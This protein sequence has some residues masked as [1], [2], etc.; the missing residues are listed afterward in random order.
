MTKP[1]LRIA[2]LLMGSALTALLFTLNGVQ[3]AAPSQENNP[4]PEPV[5]ITSDT[6]CLD[7][8]TAKDQVMDL[9]SGETLYLTI[10]SKAFTAS[11]HGQEEVACMECHTDITA[12]PHPAFEAQ[13]LREVAIDFSENCQ[14]CHEEQAADHMDG[15]H[16]QKLAE[17]NENA[18]TCSDCHNP[19]YTKHPSEPRADIVTT[20]ARCHSGIAQE[21]RES[22]HGQAL[23]TD[24]NPDVPSC[25]DCH[26]VHN[27]TDPT[28]AQFLLNSPKL[29]ADC[30]ADPVKMEPYHLNTNVLSSYVADFHG[31]TTTLFE[32][33]SPDQL[34][35]TPLCIDCHGI[36]N[37]KSVTSTES[38]VIK[39]NLLV[40]CQKCHPDATANFSDAWLSHYT[41]SSEHNPL[42]FY[43]NLFYQIF[44][45]AVL[46][47]M[48]IIVVT[49]AGRK[50]AT[51]FI[52]RGKK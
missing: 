6:Q 40:T 23:I 33:K 11:I 8:H 41:P 15:I 51:R 3:A 20:C 31:T 52:K 46:I 28:T 13:N 32:Q 2:L 30:H 36:H 45:P 25:I 47:P 4:T 26:G 35:N 16:T 48:G 1:I 34:P 18:A 21:Y 38:T 27:I 39:E 22:A 7:C 9:P 10:D 42:V 19:H 37:I 44:I 12:Y 49:D 29:C 17:G 5:A 24:D 43:V 50:L 14:D